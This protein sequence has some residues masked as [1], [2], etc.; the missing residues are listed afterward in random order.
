MDEYYT[1]IRFLPDPLRAELKAL[2]PPQ[3]AAV[4]EI[5]LR[6][7]QAVQFTVGGRLC[8]AAALLPAA[9][10]ARCLSPAMLRQCITSLCRDSVYAYED[11]LK[12]GF[13][14]LPNGSRAGVAGVRGTDGFAFITSLN[15]R[16]S[17]RIPCTLPPPLCRALDELR[18]GVLV[19]GVPGSG[20]TTFLRSIIHYLDRSDHIF[21]VA[22]ERGELLPT[23]ASARCDVYARCSRADAIQMALRCMNPQMIV[24]DELG[25]ASDAAA[26][27]SALACGVLFAASA[28]CDSLES[29]SRRPQT[30]RLLAAGAFKTL[31]LLEG[32]ARP[33]R[34][35]QVRTLA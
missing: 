20:K 32:R 1:V 10:A 13:F 2:P 29:L 26:V 33:G 25:T 31:V 19:A 14:T 11:E 34:A 16:V 17:R 8:N 3:A 4:Q 18:G 28:H 12:Q 35:V 21:C 30:A 15:L 22:D 5:R 9:Q 23:G 6:A 27:V 24:C 7:D